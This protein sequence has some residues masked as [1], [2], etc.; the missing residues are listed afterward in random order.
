MRDFDIR[1]EIKD[2]E[3]EEILKELN[4]A[5]ETIFKCY[6]RLINLGVMT[7]RQKPPAAT[8]DLTTV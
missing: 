1:I 8:D 3:V 6:N 2:G 7:I 5:Q 4:E